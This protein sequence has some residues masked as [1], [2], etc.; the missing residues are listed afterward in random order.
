LFAIAAAVTG[1][2]SQAYGIGQNL[3]T[4]PRSHDDGG[5]RWVLPGKIA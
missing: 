1:A 2:A 3:P 4:P 5:P